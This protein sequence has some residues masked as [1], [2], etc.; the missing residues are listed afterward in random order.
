MS[1]ELD[2]LNTLISQTAKVVQDILPLGPFQCKFLSAIDSLEPYAYGAAICQLLNGRRR[3]KLNI[4][5]VYGTGER[6]LK[7]DCVS[8]VVKASQNGK[9]RKVVAYEITEFGRAAITASLIMVKAAR[10]D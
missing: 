9:G 3:K 1:Q 4:G 7:R 8:I 2:E 5:Q 10:T 6:L